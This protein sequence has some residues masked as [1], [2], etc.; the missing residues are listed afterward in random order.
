M[1]IY[2]VGISPKW[3]VQRFGRDGR[4]GR[5]QKKL[6]SVL[7]WVPTQRFL[8][9]G[10]AAGSAAASKTVRPDGTIEL[11]YPDGTVKTKKL[12]QCGW[13]T[14]YPDGRFQPAECVRME[15]IP[16][17]FLPSPAIQ[18]RASGWIGRA[19]HCSPSLRCRRMITRTINWM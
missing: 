18:Y 11:R 1:F 4:S 17:R 6:T 9:V 3:P 16:A 5:L 7:L 15:A 13:D 19:E 2:S 8:Q 12:K 10:A 14:T